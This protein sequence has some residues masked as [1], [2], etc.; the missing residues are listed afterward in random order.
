[1]DTLNRGN[2]LTAKVAKGTQS[3]Q[4]VYFYGFDFVPFVHTLCTLWLIKTFKFNLTLNVI[5]NNTFVLI[6]RC[7]WVYY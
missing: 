5:K 2:P 3:S 6:D 1:M 4:R 7:L